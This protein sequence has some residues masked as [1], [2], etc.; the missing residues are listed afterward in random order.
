VTALQK[1]GEVRLKD[2]SDEF[3]MSPGEYP[4]YRLK[5]E[6][7]EESGLTRCSV[8]SG[9]KSVEFI[10]DPHRMTLLRKRK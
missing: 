2:W 6:P 4:E 7:F 5:V 10:Y 8:K 9:D 1:D 3:L